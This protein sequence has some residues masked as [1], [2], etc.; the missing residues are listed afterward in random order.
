M[1][2]QDLVVKL[3]LDSGAFGSDLRE[4]ERKAQQFSNNMQSAGKSAGNFTKEIGLSVGA[5]GKLGGMLGGAGAVIAGVGAFKSVMESTHGTAKEFK[6]TVSGFSGVLDSFQKSLASFDFSNFAGGMSDIIEQFKEFKQATMAIMDM[7]KGGVAYGMLSTGYESRI[8]DIKVDFT[9]ATTSED[10]SAYKQQ[11]QQ[12]VK[13]WRE[14]FTNYDAI[15]KEA[16]IKS[17][18]AGG[19]V[20]ESQSFVTDKWVDEQILSW[21]KKQNDKTQKARDDKNYEGISDLIGKKKKKINELNR[22][23]TDINFYSIWENL[24]K[25]KQKI[26]GEI[27]TLIKD[28]APALFRHQLYQMTEEEVKTI[29]DM[30][31]VRNENRKKIADQEAEILGWNTTV[32]EPSD[33]KTPEKSAK[34]EKQEEVILLGSIKDLTQK[35]AKEQ[36]KINTLEPFSDGW[37]KALEMLHEYQ[38][39]L[40]TIQKIIDDN[41]P[42]KEALS[43][44][45]SLDYIQSQINGI[46]QLRNTYEIGSDMWKALTDDLHCYIE[47]YNK[48][49]KTQEEWDNTYSNVIKENAEK[50]DNFNSA[51]SSSISLVGSLGSAFEGAGDDVEKYING[52]TT[53]LTTL[54]S[55]IMNFHQIYQDGIESAKNASKAVAEAS[56]LTVASSE[57]SATAQGIASASALPFPA[58]LAAVASVVATMVSLF[59]SIKS[60]TKGK[61]ADGGI[62]GGTS[63][64]GDKL[65]AMVN[66]GEMILNK[67]QQKNLSNMIGGSG[68]GQ[69]EFVISGD[70]LIGVLNNRQNKRNLIR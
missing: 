45:G 69:V 55:G 9:K 17:V 6:G 5:L 7:Q 38:D 32:S 2:K 43:A 62:V 16:V 24:E 23:L 19:L 51:I 36:E 27:N 3:L 48:L 50:Q 42:N 25:E 11:A 56:A 30:V 44:L 21:A 22:Q 15:V 68:A 31:K 65:F 1:A 18:L 10:K 40:K 37:Y 67:R 64:S 28:N 41:D 39:E 26:E 58:N 54:M 8:K 29:V 52:I 33:K 61:F 46:T 66:S 4:A 34:K 47:E 57:A 60:M 12:V 59:A 53:T 35:I 14:D 20:D 49:I 70:N 63:Y 13:E